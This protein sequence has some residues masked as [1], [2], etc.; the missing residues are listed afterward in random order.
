MFVYFGRH[1]A[2]RNDKTRLE[3]VFIEDFRDLL[4]EVCTLNCSILPIF[5]LSQIYAL[6]NICLLFLETYRKYI[7]VC[8]SFVNLKKILYNIVCAA[9]IVFLIDYILIF[10]FNI[11][12]WLL[13][14][15]HTNDICS[16]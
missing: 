12:Y 11:C 6:L 8:F 1:V 16:I 14:S 4:S 13:Y 15:F 2:E 3:S 10:N 5:F 9:Y 7:I